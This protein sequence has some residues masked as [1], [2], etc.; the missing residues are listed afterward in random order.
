MCCGRRLGGAAWRLGAGLLSGLLDDGKYC[1]ICLI[2]PSDAWLACFLTL[3]RLR[4]GDF[5]ITPEEMVGEIFDGLVRH[6]QEVS[7]RGCAGESKE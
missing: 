5:A 3:R 2:E 7:G 1:I 6:E 4:T